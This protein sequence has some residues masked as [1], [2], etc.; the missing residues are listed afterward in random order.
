MHTVFSWQDNVF[1]KIHA[2]V[3]F[4]TFPIYQSNT[5]KKSCFL[6]KKKCLDSAELIVAW[7]VLNAFFRAIHHF[8]SYIAMAIL[9]NWEEGTNQG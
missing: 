6:K 4:S 5:F 3:V 9:S 8:T 7:Q 2:W 1:E